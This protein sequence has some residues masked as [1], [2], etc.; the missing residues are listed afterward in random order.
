[1]GGEVGPIY[2]ASYRVQKGRGIGN[3]LAGLWRFA[4]P[5][6]FSGL[7]SVGK[8]AASASAAALADLGTKPVKEI[9]RDR[10]NEAGENLKRKAG[11]KLRN[12]KGGSLRIAKRARLTKIKPERGKKK[13]HSTRDRRR[14]KVAP[15]DIFSN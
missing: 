15:R 8:E 12:F 5:L 9:L 7:K 11:E 13:R 6:V 2:K 14:E 1:M 10:L 3:F 4:K